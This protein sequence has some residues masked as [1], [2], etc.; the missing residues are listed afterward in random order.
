MTETKT[1]LRAVEASNEIDFEDSEFARAMQSNVRSDRELAL[2]RMAPPI[3]A[4]DR[5]RLIEDRFEETS[6]MKLVS[7]WLKTDKPWFVLCGTTGRG[8]TLAALRATLRNHGRYMDARELE[9][10]FTARYGDDP[11]TQQE[12]LN[13]RFLV[14]DDLGRER[15]VAGM[16]SALLELVD[17]RRTGREKTIA[18]A[19]MT[20]AQFAQRYGDQRLLSRLNECAFWASIAGDDMR[21]SAP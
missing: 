18:I 2:D 16:A 17:Y 19:N 7:A 9:R 8:K 4:E 6:A 13:R 5:Q 1:A 11:E 21:R 10:V 14:V 3:T 12:L 20:R 15:D